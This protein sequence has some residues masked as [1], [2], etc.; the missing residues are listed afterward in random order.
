[1]GRLGSF[2]R[3]GL[4]VE[5]AGGDR[6]Q[7]QVELILPTELEARL[8]QGVIAVLG[9]GMSLGQIRGV[10]GDLVRDDPILDVLLVGQAQVFFGRHVAQHRAAIPT[11]HRRS[12]AA[13]DVVIARGD[14]GRERTQGVEG[15]LMAPF[16]LLGHVLLDH[17][18]GHMSGSLVHH[19][20]AMLPGA[21]GEFTLDLQLSELRVVVGIGNGAR[22]QAVADAE[23]DVV[24]GHDLANFIPVG[25]EEI[26]AMMGQAP[27]GQDAAAAADDA[28]HPAGGHRNEPQEHSGMD[29]EVIDALFGLLDQGV[30]VN[31]PAK[32]LGL[33]ADFLQGLVNRNRPNGHRRVTQDPLTGGVDVLARGQIHHRIGS[34]LGGPA[35]L[36]DLFLDARCD[37]AVADVGVD[38]H[39][40]IPADDHRLVFRMVDVAGN[41]R[42]SGGH[43]AADELR[44]DFVGNALREPT[45]H[46][47]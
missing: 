37:G 25:V 20:N 35:H 6:I 1:M 42:P 44:R 27:L 19:L 14:V 22:P 34:P 3:Q 11:N 30:A 41:D 15:G 46:T 8:A 23:A 5:F 12:D 26:L 13:G 28:G 33:A 38:L 45:E 7:T 16:Q 9:T 47:G 10:G 17:V 18:H 24:S 32:I 4:V 21:L 43:F 40:E 29:R 39:Q 36:L 2:L 31:F